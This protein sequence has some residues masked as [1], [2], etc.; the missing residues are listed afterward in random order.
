MNKKNGQL[1]L[2]GPDAGCHLGSSTQ[3][4][5]NFPHLSNKADVTPAPLPRVGNLVLTF[6]VGVADMPSRSMDLERMHRFLRPSLPICAAVPLPTYSPQQK[7]L[8]GLGPS[9]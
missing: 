3:W 4:P 1:Q 8:C 7:F 9:F 6:E 2:K 5:V